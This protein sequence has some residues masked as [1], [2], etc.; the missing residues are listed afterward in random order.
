M[1][2]NSVGQN[3]RQKLNGGAP[4]LYPVGLGFESLVADWVWVQDTLQLTENR[5][6]GAVVCPHI[7]KLCITSKSSKRIGVPIRSSE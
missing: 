4:G 6:E 7:V 2:I 1:S 5:W 3:Y